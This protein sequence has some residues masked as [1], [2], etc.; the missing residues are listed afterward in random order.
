MRA[1]VITLAICGIWVMAIIGWFHSFRVVAPLEATVPSDLPEYLARFIRG[2]VSLNP[3]EL[4][5]LKAGKPVSKLLDTD[6][7][8]EVG[9]FGAV[10]IA[11]PA[12]EYVRAMKDIE[13]F[14]RGDEFLVTK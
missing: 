14:E 11:A 3:E 2:L 4:K 10:W 13:H 12:S 1:R 9:V 7:D 5:S 8:R 6:P